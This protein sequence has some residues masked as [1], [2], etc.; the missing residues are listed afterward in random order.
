MRFLRWCRRTYVRLA[1]FSRQFVA[2]MPWRL[3]F[4][5]SAGFGAVLFLGYVFNSVWIKAFAPVGMVWSLALPII[6]RRSFYARCGKAI[7]LIPPA[8]WIVVWLYFRWR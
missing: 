4:M 3:A 7:L 5:L 2:M 6:P 8:M 1:E